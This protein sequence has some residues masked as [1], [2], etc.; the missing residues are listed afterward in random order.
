MNNVKKQSFHLESYTLECGVSLPITL[1]FETYGSLNEDKSNVILI[2]HY[3][4]ASSHAAGK[5]RPDDVAAGYWDALIGQG[6]AIDTEKYFVISTDN[7]CNV[8]FKNPDIITTGPRT[9]NPKTGKRWGASFPQFTFR[10]MAGIQHEF[11]MKQLGIKKLHAVAGPS[12]G[13]FIALEWAVNYPDE[14][15]RVIGVI[16]NPQNP[17]LTSFN[18]I[19]HAMRAIALDPNWNHGDYEE[20]QEPTEGLYLAVQMMNAGAFTPEFYEA[21]Y[22]R[23][24]KE[25]APY[26]DIHI[27]TS[28]EKKLGDAIKMNSGLIDASHWYYTCRATL[29]HDIARGHGS[30]EN[31]LKKIKAKTLMISCTRDLLQPTLYNQKMVD[32][33]KENGQD[34]KLVKIESLNGHMTGVL[35]G[36]LFEEEIRSA[37]E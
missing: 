14:V 17:S 6:K 28:F 26:E 32:L 29:L 30:L 31:A 9:I 7:L 19:Q 11:L 27:P 16:T 23:D 18:V 15:E 20:G 22:P 1:G 36:K 37:L 24:S 5:Y 25:E 33:M 35:E 2:A 13:G 10:D 34:A 8:Q 4:S 12:A 21:T 3:F